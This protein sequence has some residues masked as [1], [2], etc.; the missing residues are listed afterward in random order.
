MMSQPL[1]LAELIFHM[2]DLGWLGSLAVA[3]GLAAVVFAYTAGLRAQQH[4]PQARFGLLTLRMTAIICLLVA[5]AHPSCVS[6]QTIL[7]KPLLAI[8][9]DDSASM[10]RPIGAPDEIGTRYA[11]ATGLLRDT[12][13]PRLRDTHRIELFDVEAR[14]LGPN[15]PPANPEVRRSPLTETLLRVQRT[16]AGQRLAGIVLLSDGTEVTERPPAENIQQLRV[17]VHTIE[18]VPATQRVVGPPDLAIESVSANQRVI[19]GNT[20]RVTVDLTAAGDVGAASV[21]LNVI[22][23]GQIVATTTVAWPAGE[24]NL[25]AELEFTARRPGRFTHTVQ[26]G[27]LPGETELA[28][29]RATFPLIVRAKALTVFYIDGVLRW[30]GKFIR[31]ALTADPDLNVVATTRTVP[32]GTDRGSQGLL[33][34]EQ[35]ADVDVVILGDIEATFF[36]T[37]EL[38]ALRTWVIEG[39][40]ALVITGGYSSYGPAGFGHSAL[41][42]VLPIEF[43]ADPNP[44]IEQSFNL[45][46]TEAGRQHA[47]FHLTRDRVRDAAFYQAL[48]PLDGC[49]R[50]AAVKPGAEV[51]AVN[52]NV[53]GPDGT[54]GLPV[55]VIQRVGAGRT[56]AIAT[57]TTW[58]WRM[59]VGGF[60]G[61]SSFY[62]MFW[63]QLVRALVGEDDLTDPP[64]YVT[65]DAAQ[66]RLGQ[67]V[68]V[69]IEYR[70]PAE[71]ET[72]Q[73]REVSAFTLDEAG[74]QTTIPLTE[75]TPSKYTGA[76]SARAP[77][78]IDV[79]AIAHVSTHD[80][81]SPNA[82]EVF[83]RVATIDV[84]HPDLELRSPRANPQWL[85]QVAQRTGGRT[86]APDQI[87]QWAAQLPAEQFETTR[88]VS[89]GARGDLLLGGLA[90]LLLCAEWILRRWSRLV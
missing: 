88:A 39:G 43:S 49:A 41:R 21:P 64:L 81:P 63:G 68:N 53:A 69:K 86:V 61:D 48:P 10:S 4:A 85:A 28:N 8:V 25:R 76:F 18:L 37:A 45:K 46:L 15:A 80:D 38:E 51:L 71:A 1:I 12:L 34:A 83:A 55:L 35:L 60:T 75:V 22:E 19:V 65:T 32:P 29:N 7:E 30:E 58:R 47:I 16:L 87:D 50:I 70:P 77:G 17:P 54:Q 62:Q 67:T 13:V 3:G 82:D 5:L 11:A 31:Q 20:V 42:D 72:T 56:L 26:L 73:P 79:Q 23:A 74:Q 36:S 14:E 59:V 78:R 27:A 2:P 9:L 90:L 84:A 24:T 33:T 66:Y 44:Q 6:Q 40:G 89:S 57:D 52:P